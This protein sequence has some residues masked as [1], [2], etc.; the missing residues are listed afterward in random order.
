M[1]SNISLTARTI[2]DFGF[3]EFFRKSKIQNLKSLDY[4]HKNSKCPPN[5]RGDKDSEIISHTM[6]KFIKFNLLKKANIYPI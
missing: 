6:E 2:L 4:S 1:R 5:I 3:S